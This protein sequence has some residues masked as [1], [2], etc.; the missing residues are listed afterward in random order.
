VS[1]LL[2]LSEMMMDDSENPTQ[3]LNSIFQPCL[4][5][6]SYLHHDAVTQPDPDLAKRLGHFGYALRYRG[7]CEE[8]CAA[9]VASL[10]ITRRLHAA[11]PGDFEVD[12]AHCLCDYGISLHSWEKFE[13]ACAAYGE[14]LTI[15]RHLYD[16]ESTRY[17]VMDDLINILNNYKISLGRCG[18]NSEAHDLEVELATF[19]TECE[20]R[21]HIVD[22]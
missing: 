20:K 17:I 13:E 5:L 2:Y 1:N 22:D 19:I 21:L 15:T 16:Q 18:R 6:S 3:T 11:R 4:Q 12:L 14:S 9:Y 10:S 8:A 7:L